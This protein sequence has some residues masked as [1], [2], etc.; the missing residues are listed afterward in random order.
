MAF[1]EYLFNKLLLQ[2]GINKGQLSS[3]YLPSY[4][5]LHIAPL[6]V[7]SQIYSVAN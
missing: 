5:E 7:S 2:I 1:Q 6:D 4:P 3:E